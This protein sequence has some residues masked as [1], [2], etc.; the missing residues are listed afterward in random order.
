MFGV[1]HIVSQ[2][3]GPIF[4]A[5]N[6]NGDIYSALIETDLP[7][8]LENLPLRLRLNLWFQQDACPSHTS[9]VARASLNAVSTNG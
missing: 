2:I 3:V 9:R 5:E 6:I 4:F 8:L 1:A 7:V